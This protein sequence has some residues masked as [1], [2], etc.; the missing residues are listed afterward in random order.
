[1]SCVN[2][3]VTCGYGCGSVAAMASRAAQQS[4]R[5]GSPAFLLDPRSGISWTPGSSRE[6]SPLPSDRLSLPHAGQI[7]DDVRAS[8]RLSRRVLK[9]L[10]SVE[11]EMKVDGEDPPFYSPWTFWFEK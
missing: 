5:E 10:K 9:E 8:P 3:R 6:S 1:M 4:S 7:G 11:E 2:G